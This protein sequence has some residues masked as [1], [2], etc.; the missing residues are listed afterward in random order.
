[1]IMKC[2]KHG[3]VERP[4]RLCKAERYLDQVRKGLREHESA[5]EGAGPMSEDITPLQIQFRA[6]MLRLQN[7][8]RFKSRE[9][10]NRR[11]IVRCYPTTVL[12][13]LCH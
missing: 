11:R 9:W 10:M 7:Q 13:N 5:E 2:P 6:Y 1:V 8:E 12:E 3:R 4:C